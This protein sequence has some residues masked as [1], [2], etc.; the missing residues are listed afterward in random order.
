MHLIKRIIPPKTFCGVP[1]AE[2]LS[3]LDAEVAII[4]ASHGT[5]YTPGKA[6]HSANSPGTVRAALS[7]YSANRE[8]FDFDAMTEI[9]GGASVMDCGDI[10]GDLNDGEKNRARITE[11]V[12][13]ILARG[14]IP[15]LLGGDDSVPIPFFHAYAGS[16]P[17]MIVQIDAHIDWRD[18]VHGITHGFSSTMRRASEMEHIQHMIQIGARGP[19]SA[20][21]QEINDAKSWGSLFFTARDVAKHGMQPAIDSIPNGAKVI[22]SIDVD[23]LDPTLVPGVILPAPGGVGYQ[24][25][26]DLIEGVAQRAQIVGAT[27]VEF[28]PENDIQGLGAR[29]IARLA[30][31]L[32]AAIG[33]QINH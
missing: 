1:Y 25:M 26:L 7:W 8:Q 27:F 33:Q 5:P 15:I 23:G 2:D 31:V 22:F 29:A 16:D 14:T 13:L 28:V 4:G 19:G 30:S 18:E 21:R 11:T 3:T 6:S 24:Q 17:L 9:L 10:P 12:S 20:R 32:I